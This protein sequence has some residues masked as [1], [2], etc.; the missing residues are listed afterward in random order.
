MRRLRKII[1]GIGILVL[2]IVLGYW[3][4][5]YRGAK[6]W[7]EY[8]PVLIEAGVPL[9]DKWNQPAEP[10]PDEENFWKHPLLASLVEFDRPDDI[11]EEDNYHHPAH[12]ERFKTLTDDWPENFAWEPSS[13]YSTGV[14]IDITELKKALG[15]TDDGPPAQ[16]VANYISRHDEV[17][18]EIV[19]AAQRPYAR[20]PNPYNS[21]DFM[22]MA[23]ASVPYYNDIIGVIRYFSLRMQ[24]ALSVDDMEKARES[25][26]V[27]QRFLDSLSHEEMLIGGLVEITLHA[28]AF[29]GIWHGLA[30]RKW[31]DEDLKNISEFYLKS[32]LAVRLA[33]TFKRELVFSAKSMDFLKS[34]S[35]KEIK[36]L[37]GPMQLITGPKSGPNPAGLIVLTPDG[38]FDQ[39]KVH[40]SRA[41]LNHTI[42]PLESG[43][44]ILASNSSPEEAGFLPY[45]IFGDMTVV[46]YSHII[47]KFAIC[48]HYQNAA[49][50]ACALE[51][52][53]IKNGKYPENLDALVPEFLESLPQD[54]ITRTPL[55]YIPSEDGRFILYSVGWN[56]I[57]E[58]GKLHKES[59][60]RIDYEKGD[61]VWG[62][63]RL[64]PKAKEETAKG[65]KRKKKKRVSPQT[66]DAPS[67]N[68]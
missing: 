28:I 52:Y 59:G 36:D 33:E 4:E 13:D 48:Q 45:R 39:N 6:A 8:Q 61:W 26:I 24:V 25:L 29:T 9:G 3:I 63:S 5:N 56:Q 15:I 40:H 46:V 66:D 20:L 34:A 27:I 47:M 55:R 1:I 41:M 60:K 7:E 18:G 16:A 51:R 38:W 2:L 35:L 10:I 62:C 53:Y 42:K 68:D 17:A 14:L 12:V 43:N 58:K 65:I 11:W 67:S 54:V 21:D 44:W 19:D 50:T 49:A 23:Q 57:N 22:E 37:L 64:V 30:L 32:D 31:Q